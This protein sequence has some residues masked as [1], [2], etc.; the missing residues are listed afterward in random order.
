MVTHYEL[1]GT[2]QYAPCTKCQQ[3]IEIRRYPK[4][5]GPFVFVWHKGPEGVLCPN[6]GG[7]VWNGRVK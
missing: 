4:T 2:K 1:P 3:D 7:S 5:A 6:S